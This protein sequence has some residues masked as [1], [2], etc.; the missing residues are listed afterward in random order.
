MKLPPDRVS[1]LSG[2]AGVACLILISFASPAAAADRNPRQTYRDVEYYVPPPV[3]EQRGLSE[4][5]LRLADRY[6]VDGIGTVPATGPFGIKGTAD[7]VSIGTGPGVHCI[8]NIHWIDQYE[9]L[10][11][12]GGSGIFNIPGGVSYLNPSMMLMGIAPSR[13]KLEFLLV[14]NKGLP[15]GG[16]A[17]IAGHRATLRAPCV[18]AP[19]LFLAMNPAHRFAGR[20]PDSCERITRIDAKP[21]STVVHMDIDIEIN[22]ELVSQFQMTLRRPKKAGRR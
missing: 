15:E 16:E 2:R 18:N 9:I 21:G 17:S 8:F 13:R 19:T 14:D 12:E 3:T 6:S 5:L 1:K 4:W 10:M 20:R 7:C 22:G 11:G